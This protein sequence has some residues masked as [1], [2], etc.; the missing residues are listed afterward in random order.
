MLF[1]SYAFILGFL[2][3]VLL[4]FIWVSRWSHTLAAS[5]LAAASLFFYGWW[6][7]QFVPLLVGSILF[8][9]MIGR[10]T[11]R[12]RSRVLLLIGVTVDLMVLG[13]YK[14]A[15]FF[16]DSFDHATGLDIRLTQIVLPIG[17]SFFTFTQIA[18]LMD[19][20]AGKVRE[21]RLVHYFLFVTYFPHLVAGPVLHHKQMMP[22]FGDPSTYRLQWNNIAIGL[23]IFAIGLF[24]KT[25]CADG[26]AGFANPVFTSAG[27]GAPVLLFEAWVGALAYTLQLY[28]DFSGYS[29]MAIGL[30]RLFNVKLPLNFN[31][32][33][34]STNIIEFWRRWHM[35]L[36][37]FLRDYLYVP[38]GGNRKGPTR[39]YANLMITMLLGGLWHGAGWTFVVWGGLHGVY[40]M[41]NHGWRGLRARVGLQ[42]TH[43]GYASHGVSCLLTFLAVVVA[44]V[45]F[46]A[47][48]LRSALCLLRGMAG[49]NGVSL[50]ESLAGTSLAQ[51]L[52]GGSVA[53][54]GL[55]TN[56]NSNGVEPILW[57]VSLLAAVWAL[58]NTQELMRD[59]GPSYA[60]VDSP[61]LLSNLRWRPTWRWVFLI[62]GC[63]ATGFLALSKVSAFLY[64]QF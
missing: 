8:N 18:F 55:L 57:I 52:G 19:T 29:D 13:Y 28:F 41:I 2:P 27:E 42:T 44:W 63:L 10:A 4:G 58:P 49:M 32:P 54:S 24:K 9:Y 22:Q 37:Q 17:I 30:S 56:S 6:S 50:P 25:I 60:P 40:L 48:D 16:I 1:N 31:S 12:S 14:Y 46:R 11:A 7:V 35:T 21:Y 33:Y 59:F 26:V 20:W 38:L 64:F 43:S 62:A 51:W 23:T 47:T 36:S 34:K 5:W 61:R 53:F 15:N 39:R 3:V 45:F